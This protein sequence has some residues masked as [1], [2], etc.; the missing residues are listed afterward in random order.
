M[1][2]DFIRISITWRTAASELYYLLLQQTS[3]FLMNFKVPS[4]LS[5]VTSLSLQI[6][7]LNIIIFWGRWGGGVVVVVGGGG[8]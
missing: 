7:P 4:V 8:T 2:S 3:G 5:L 1:F 6:N